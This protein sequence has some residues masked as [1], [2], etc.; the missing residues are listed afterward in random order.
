LRKELGD[1]KG[2]GWVTTKLCFSMTG[3]AI[4]EVKWRRQAMLLES[5]YGGRDGEGAVG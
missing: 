3:P 4:Y 2:W 1:R 5:S